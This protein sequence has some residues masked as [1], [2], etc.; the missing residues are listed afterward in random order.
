[1]AMPIDDFVEDGALVF[2]VK[3]EGA[4]SDPSGGDDLVDLRVVVAAPREDVARVVQDLLPPLALTHA[5]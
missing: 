5:S 3:V 1:M 4:A 2:E